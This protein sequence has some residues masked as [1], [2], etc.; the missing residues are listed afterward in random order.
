MGW[1]SAWGGARLYNTWY[2]EAVWKGTITAAGGTRFN[3]IQTFGS[4]VDVPEE[5]VEQKSENVVGFE[6]RTSGNLMGFWYM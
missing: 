5:V 2:R 3:S 6:T 1:C 4:V